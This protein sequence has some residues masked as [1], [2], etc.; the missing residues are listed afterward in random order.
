M[1]IAIKIPAELVPSRASLS[2]IT[3][4][5]TVHLDRATEQMAKSRQFDPALLQHVSLR[6]GSTSISLATTLAHQ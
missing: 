1:E 6:M 5:N 3:L 4:S 2:A